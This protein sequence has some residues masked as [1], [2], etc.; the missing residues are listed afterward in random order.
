MTNAPL[1]LALRYLRPTRSFISVITVISMLGVML[2]VGV[3]VFV[4]SVFSGWQREFRQMLIGFEPHVMVQ[5]VSNR[6]GA[7]DGPKSVD[8]RELRKALAQLPEV[9]SAVPV[10]EGVVVVENA[11]SLQGVSVIG[12]TDEKDNA[13]LNKLSK[14]I[15]E[16]RFDLKGDS[17]ILSDKFARELGA[18]VGDTLVVHAADSV[19]QF[20]TKVREIPE[21]AEEKKRAEALDNVTVLS[22]DLTLVATL[23][24]DTAGQRGYVPL[25]VAQEFFNLESRVS[26]IEL[27]LKDPDNAERIMDKVYQ[28]GAVPYGWGYRTWVQEHGMMLESVENQRT[29]MW[30]LLLFIMLVAA[31]CVMNTTITVTVKKRREIGILTALGTRAWQIIAIFVSQAGIVA[32]VGVVAGLAGG[33]FFLGIRNWLRD[34]IANLTGRDIFPQDIYFLSSI[35]AHTDITDL[36]TICSTAVALCLMAALVPS[37][38]AAR[39]DPA[40]ALRDGG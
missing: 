40:V 2:G 33:F 31:I 30:F 28:S 34:Q 14:H 25:H 29:M 23:R 39:V 26:G 1:F 3:L 36:L 7:P 19:N 24:A 20:I 21:D 4:M 11:G 5:P 8:W 6:E 27:E 16:G 22:K 17:L 12:L 37:W 38:F 18:K 10:G 15:K 32:L 9:E 35:P 13:L